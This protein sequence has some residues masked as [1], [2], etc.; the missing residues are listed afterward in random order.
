[1]NNLINTEIEQWLRIKNSWL[2]NHG[3]NDTYLNL[4]VIPFQYLN[5]PEQYH[6]SNNYDLLLPPLQ[7]LGNLEEN[8]NNKTLVISLE[9]LKTDLDFLNQYNY[10]FGLPIHYNVLNDFSNY[11]RHQLQ[12]ENYTSYQLNYFSVF[13]NML[14]L[15]SPHSPNSNKYWRYLDYFSNGFLGNQNLGSHNLET[16]GNAIID[17]PIIP[18]WA[19][20]HPNFV[21]NININNLFLAKL[22]SIQPSKILVLGKS[23]IG[24]VRNY[25]GIG[26]DNFQLLAMNGNHP[27]YVS[28]LDMN[29]GRLKI[30]YRRFFSNGGGSYNDA[31]DLGELIRN[32][33]N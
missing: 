30:F 29:W 2:E 23:K 17:M 13:S 3:I 6:A 24:L 9:P 4:N 31:Y 26:D 12:I 25:L 7:I 28:N 14:G 5:N 21:N 27:V 10:F 15:A 19:R 20:R 1:M 33:I 11:G 32:Q 22:N 8:S 18:L 16:I